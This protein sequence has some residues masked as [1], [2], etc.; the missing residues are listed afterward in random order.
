MPIL[1][2][3]CGH[4][5]SAALM[6]AGQIVGAVQEERFTKTKNQD[7]FPI[8]SIEH[9]LRT[10]LQ[11]DV[12]QLK[13]VAF[14]MKDIDPFGLAISRYSK[15]TVHDHIRENNE[16]WK[17]VFYEGA[18]NN[19]SY[20]RELFRQGRFLNNHSGVDTSFMNSGT[21]IDELIRFVS[22][23][24]RPSILRQR[25][26]YQGSSTAYDHHLCH[27]MYAFYG[28]PIPHKYW[29][30]TLVLTADSWGD[31]QNWSAYLV[32]DNGYLKK[33]GGGK[34]HGVARIYRFITLILGMKPLEHEYKVMGLS[35]YVSPNKYVTAVEDILS[36]ALDFRNGKFVN[37][38]PLKDSYFDLKN[39]LEG[40]RF[41]NIAAALQNWTT[42]LTSAWM[43]HWLRE[44]NTD[45]VCFSGGLSMNIKSNGDLLNLPEIKRFSVPASGGDETGCIGACFAGALEHKLK[46]E[47]MN[48]VYLGALEDHMD[49]EDDWETGV[50]NAG[51]NPAD[52]E[53]IP[54]V[55]SPDLAK[56]LAADVIVARCVG[57]MEFGAR[58]LGNRSILANPKNPNNLKYINDVI[59]S[60]DFWMPFT[61]SILEEEANGY[62]FNPKRVASPFMTIGFPTTQLARNDIPAALHPGDLSAR[63][64]FVSKK[65]NPA[66]WMLIRDFQLLTGIPALL[67]T[68]LN[69]HGNPMCA[70]VADAARTL[71]LSG[72]EVLA[73]SG[74]RLLIKKRAS[75]RIKNLIKI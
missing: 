8:R 59:K 31:G 51:G 46:V 32:E 33:V 57:L 17:K 71:A 70:S 2:I 40:H 22:D 27:A 45:G 72:L 53:L 63:P 61:P 7:A 39:R 64:Q 18:P 73:L 43:L 69:L 58:A 44:T 23:E 41:D 49:A 67:N 65:T 19:G 62:I 34:E 25:F 6:I 42:R 55:K 66:Y 52:F 12:S 60:R 47:P 13:H 36:E 20:W 50:L 68:S 21:S 54:D 1:G 3:H 56:L 75:V 26:G 74:N 37:D 14:F 30:D 29:N 9:L 28:S 10:H 11:G 35:G 24:L 5:S 4:N 16:Y 48:H 38:L 15:F